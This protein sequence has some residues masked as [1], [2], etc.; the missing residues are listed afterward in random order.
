MSFKVGRL[1]STVLVFSLF[2]QMHIAEN[3]YAAGRPKIV[4]SSTRDGNSE[5]YA[6]EIDGSNQVRLTNHPADDYGPSWSPDGRR[7]AFVSNRDSGVDHIYVMDSDGRNVTQLTRE[8]NGS[9]PAW[10]PDG[11][12]IAF[13]RN[14]GGNQ[15]W[16]MDADGQNQTRLTHV[17]FNVLPAWSPDGRR[18]AFVSSNKEI[19]VMDENGNNRESLI[20]ERLPWGNPSWSPDGQWI[21]FDSEHDFIIQIHVVKTDG[22]GLRKRLTGEFRNKVRAA[23]SPD[24]NT[25]AY[26]QEVPGINTTTIH[27]MTADGE[28]LKQLSE[29]IF[30]SDTDPDWYAPV[31]W[32]VSPAANFV[33]IWGEIKEPTLGRQ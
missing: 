5:I 8:S 9:H 16:V 23:W 31:G 7:I 1:F 14:K 20:R 22:S 19:N 18:I 30:E 29:T 6:M 10:S 24:G 11:A 28:H 13:T 26:V 21:A 25:I 17:G 33:T 27:L 32:S 2:I 4:F 15:I 3:G 12:K